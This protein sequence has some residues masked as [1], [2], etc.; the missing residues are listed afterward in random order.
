MSVHLQYVCLQ[1]FYYVKVRKYINVEKDA[2][3]GTTTLVYLQG[4]Q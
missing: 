1:K 3:R 4:V 2:T